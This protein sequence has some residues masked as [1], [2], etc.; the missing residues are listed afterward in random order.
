LTNVNFSKF[1]VIFIVIVVNS[2][3]STETKE[4]SILLSI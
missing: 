1:H 4:T 2:S 3:N